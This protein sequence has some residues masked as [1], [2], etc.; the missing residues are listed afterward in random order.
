MGG[1]VYRRLI[2]SLL[3]LLVMAGSAHS[4]DY[5]YDKLGRLEQVHYSDGTVIRYA[6]D[7]VGN[8]LEQRVVK[9]MIDISASPASSATA[10]TP[11]AFTGIGK[12][13]GP[14]EYRWWLCSGGQWGLARDY[15]TDPRWDWSTVSASSGNYQVQ[16]DVRTVGST[17]DREGFQTIPYNLIAG[18]PGHVDLSGSPGSPCMGG[19]RVAFAASASGGG[20]WEYLFEVLGADGRWATGRPAGSSS[21]WQWDTTTLP[22]GTYQVRV[23]VCPAGAPSVCETSAPLTYRIDNSRI[24]SLSLSADPPGPSPP[25]TSV[26][27]TATALGGVPPYIYQFAFRDPSGNLLADPYP[28]SSSN[29][30]RWTTAG[31]P[32]GN[33]TVEVRARSYGSAID[34]EAYSKLVYPL[35]IPPVDNVSLTANPAGPSQPGPVVTFTAAASGGVSPQYRWFVYNS[36]GTLVNYSPGGYQTSNVFNWGTSNK[37]VGAYQVVVD[38]RST[39]SAADKEATRTMTYVLAIPPVA[40][41]SLSANPTAP[42]SPGPVVAFTAT[43]SG[44]VSPQFRWFVYNSAGTLVN[45]SPGGYQASALFNWGTSNKT[46]GDYRVVV[47]ARSTGSAADKEATLTIFYKLKQ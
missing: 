47:D 2:L 42:I 1:Q 27:L 21:A 17:S 37:T 28:Y 23:R 10:G 18:P 15:S 24:V 26:Q 5:Y 30:I 11:V 45:Y 19:T 4:T 33:Y 40:A 8:R 6:Y 44:G 9:V 39:G 46:A 43:A 14:F 35:F 12:G 3:F 41:V 13:S 29:Q 31:R 20:P 7:N 22:T 16:A 34:N 25:G 38:S 32:P 36:A